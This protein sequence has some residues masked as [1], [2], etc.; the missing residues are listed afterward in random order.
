MLA[1]HTHNEHKENINRLETE[2]KKIKK[3]ACTGC[4]G[5]KKT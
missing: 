1:R 3:E 4:T 2:S 5:E